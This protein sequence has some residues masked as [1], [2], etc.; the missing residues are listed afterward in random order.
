MSML[1][2]D[3]FPKGNLGKEERWSQLERCQ[4]RWFTKRTRGGSFP[5]CLPAFRRTLTGWA[6]GPGEEPGRRAG[7]PQGCAALLPRPIASNTKT[8]KPGTFSDALKLSLHM[9]EVLMG[10]DKGG[11]DW[12]SQ[13]SC[14]C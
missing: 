6:A 8:T 9:S 3:R 4:G 10:V 11:I 13:R 7:R 1:M 14:L 12:N 5:T 2:L